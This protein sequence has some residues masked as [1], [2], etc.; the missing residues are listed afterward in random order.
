M[1]VSI[2]ELKGKILEKIIN[3]NNDELIFILKDGTRYKMFH[4]QECCESVVTDDIIGD[5]DD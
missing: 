5:M 1:Q 2:S 4:E 3:E